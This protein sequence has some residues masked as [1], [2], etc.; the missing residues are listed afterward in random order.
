MTGFNV[1]VV[2]ELT[3]GGSL[4]MFCYKHFDLC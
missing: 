3:K 4:R 2:A 1:E